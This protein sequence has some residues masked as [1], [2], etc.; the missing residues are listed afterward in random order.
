[1]ASIQVHG[2]HVEYD[3]H[4]PNHM[5]HHDGLD[6]LTHR[7]DKDEAEVL[8]RQ[9]KEHG[10]AQFETQLGKNYTVVHNPNGTFT[11]AKR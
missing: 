9:A 7:I 4:D 11:V 2:H 1:M 8:F 5:D 3:P 10:S 6:H